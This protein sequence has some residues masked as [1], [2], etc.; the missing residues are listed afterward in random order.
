M[1]SKTEIAVRFRTARKGLGLSQQQVALKAAVTQKTVSRI[2]NGKDN[3][4]IDS[5]EAIGKV[6]GVRLTFIEEP[7]LTK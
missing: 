5:V 2:E 7:V 1:D 6:L 4:S 3:T